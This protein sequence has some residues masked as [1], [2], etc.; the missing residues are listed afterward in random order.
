[1]RLPRKKKNTKKNVNEATKKKPQ[2]YVNEATKKKP[3]I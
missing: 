3:Q 1:M 2:I